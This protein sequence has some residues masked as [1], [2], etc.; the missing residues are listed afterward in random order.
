[1]ALQWTNSYPVGLKLNDEL[2]E[3]FCT[4][5]ILAVDLWHACWYLSHIPEM[6]SWTLIPL[7]HLGILRPAFN[8]LPHII[9]LTGMA[10]FCGNTLALAIAS[11]F[12]A[13]STF[14]LWTVYRIF[15]FIFYWHIR[16]L[17]FLFN[18][19]RGQ[20]LSSPPRSRC[21]WLTI[22][23]SIW[24]RTLRSAG[25]KFNVL[26]NRTEPATYQLDQLILGTI[27]F[28]IT[29]FLFPTVL[30][31]YLLLSVVSLFSGSL[32]HLIM[33]CW[34]SPI[35]LRLACWQSPFTQW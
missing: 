22:K 7:H 6:I 12:F 24:L 9:Y 19:F 27:L 8:V 20:M 17:Q 5:S 32:P 14:H 11:D 34:P 15:T 1:M 35:F 28:T 26:R 4:G 18:I 10:S 31:F 23:I 3:A 2:C 25:R 29:T 33:N 30:A 16:T 13:L 21:L